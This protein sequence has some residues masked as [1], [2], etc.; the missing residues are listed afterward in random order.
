VTTRIKLIRH[1]AIDTG[2]R[3]CGSLDVPLTAAGR[4]HVHSLIDLGRKQPVP[5]A[6]YSSS[7]TRAVEVASALGRSWSIEPRLVEWAREI[8]CGDLEGIPLHDLQRDHPEIWARNQA[9]TD[10]G[11]AWPGGETYAEF[12][13]RVLSGL[14]T[15]AI[16]HAGAR[17]AVVTHAGVISQVLGAIKGRPACVWEADRPEPLTATEV[18]CEDGVPI[19]VLTY[20]VADWY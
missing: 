15:A 18:A 2:R 10:D 6:L 19:A 17:I 1:A 16:A 9:Q 5:H 8:H 7:L 13:T 4:A 12:R 3:L 20:N 14:R 11:F